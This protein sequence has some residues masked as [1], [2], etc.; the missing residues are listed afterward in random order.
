MSRD[1]IR[2][3]E[4]F[5]VFCDGLEQAGLDVYARR[6]RDIARHLIETKQM[7]DFTATTLK[8]VQERCERQEVILRGAAYDAIRPDP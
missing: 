3:A 1:L 4:D 5:I 6:G 7:L 8:A 2:E